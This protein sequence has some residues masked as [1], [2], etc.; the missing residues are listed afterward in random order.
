MDTIYNQESFVLLALYCNQHIPE[1]MEHKPY[2]ILDIPNL[3]SWLSLKLE[4][5]TST[6]SSAHDWRLLDL[7]LC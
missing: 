4:V 7:V 2:R 1:Q 6:S 3:Y 5:F